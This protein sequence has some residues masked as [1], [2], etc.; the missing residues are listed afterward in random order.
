MQRRRVLSRKLRRSA[1]FTLIEMM[2]VVAIVAVL[3]ALAYYGLRKYTR[4]AIVSEGT[5]MVTGILTNQG[6]YFSEVG[7]YADISQNIS[8]TKSK[9]FPTIT[10]GKVTQW[11]EACS[12]RCNAGMSWDLINFRASGPVRFGYATIADSAKS[13]SQRNGGALSPKDGFPDDTATLTA[14]FNAPAPHPWAAVG[15][16]SLPSDNSKGIAIVG[17][18]LTNR[19]TVDDEDN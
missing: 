18:T 13:P 10:P 15:A 17:T 2:I 7:A 8:S 11:G 16:L 1:G 3:G 12:S 14:L 9:Y 19:L 4:A 5:E 6:A